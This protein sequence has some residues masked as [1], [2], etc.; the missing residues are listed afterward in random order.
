MTTRS[1]APL[2]GLYLFTSKIGGGKCHVEGKPTSRILLI[3]HQVPLHSHL[4]QYIGPHEE[5]WFQKSY[6]PP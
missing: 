5:Q 6:P 4:S 1:A 2:E 3:K